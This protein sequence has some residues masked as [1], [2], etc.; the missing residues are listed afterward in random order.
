MIMKM[1]FL[2]VVEGHQNTLLMEA[3]SPSEESVNFYQTTCCRKSEVT[4]FHNV[5]PNGNTTK[6]LLMYARRNR[7]RHTVN[8]SCTEASPLSTLLLRMEWLERNSTQQL[9]G[10]L[11]VHSL[12]NF[13]RFSSPSAQVGEFFALSVC[14]L[15]YAV[16]KT[17]NVSRKHSLGFIPKL[18][19]EKT[20]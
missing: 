19:F 4:R 16:L 8:K 11:F 14:R 18:T 13:L 9:L 3:V 6:L 1:A 5:L 17:G 10:L 15:L 2:W 12:F 7:R 20:G